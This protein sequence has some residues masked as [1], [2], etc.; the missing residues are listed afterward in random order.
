[1]STVGTITKIATDVVGRAAHAVTHPVG[2]VSSIAGHARRTAAAVVSGVGD[3]AGTSSSDGDLRP[4]DAAARTTF[5]ESPHR[6]VEPAEPVQPAESVDPSTTEPKAASRESAH[7]GRGTDPSD[8]WQ[9]ELDDGA[10]I[11]INPA[12]G[13]PSTAQVG[14]DEPLLDASVA[15]AVRSE[16]ETMGR[17]ADPDKGR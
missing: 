1:M 3:V 6:N 7:H 8:D 4:E 11:G 17:A 16:S 15:K 5:Y 13:L 10:D 12:T 9:D 2:T 14:D